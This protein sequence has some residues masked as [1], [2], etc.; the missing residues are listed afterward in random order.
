VIHRLELST[1]FSSHRR[2]RVD[3]P[4]PGTAKAYDDERA[5][6]V[7]RLYDCRKGGECKMERVADVRV[8]DRRESW[9]FF[10]PGMDELYPTT[11]K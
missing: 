11:V 7:A 3:R 6:T 2:E 1:W 9:R 8:G 5:T 4:T 10:K